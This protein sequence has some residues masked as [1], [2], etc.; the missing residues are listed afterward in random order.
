[1]SYAPWER[2]WMMSLH[3]SR[4]GLGAEPGAYSTRKKHWLVQHAA[5]P[6]GDLSEL[7]TKTTPLTERGMCHSSRP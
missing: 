7:R 3:M 2:T 6:S 1:M 4:L 5:G